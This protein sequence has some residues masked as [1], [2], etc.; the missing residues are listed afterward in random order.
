MIARAVED[1]GRRLHDLRVEEWEDGAVAIA[2]MAAAVAAATIRPDLAW[3]L[4]LGAGFVGYRALRAAWRRWEL[5]D[6]LVGESD[7]YAIAEVRARAEHEASMSSRRTFSRMIRGWLE[8]RDN[9]RIAAVSEEL[10]DLADVLLDA[11]L[12]LE[13]AQAVACSR[14]LTDPTT[15]PLLNTLLPAE[16][17]RSRILQIRAGFHASA[18]SSR[19]GEDIHVAPT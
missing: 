15:S 5:V 8:L 12:E 10:A 7:A 3:P 9:A 11:S 16:D 19:S 17:L 14:L 6:R 4:F 2:A 1:A 13:P 18:S